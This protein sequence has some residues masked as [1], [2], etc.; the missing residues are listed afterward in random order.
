MDSKEQAYQRESYTDEHCGDDSGQT[1]L[2]FS[3]VK[4]IIATVPDAL[5]PS[6]DAIFC[7]AK[8]AELFI[9]YLVKNVAKKYGENVDY[10]EVAEYV[11]ENDELEYLHDFFPRRLTYEVALNHVKSKEEEFL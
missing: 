10:D 2:P 4:T 6:P 11:Q 8:G 1:T 9:E 5:S 7:V 3:R